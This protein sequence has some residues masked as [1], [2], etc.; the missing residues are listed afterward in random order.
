MPPRFV[1]ARDAVLAA[2]RDG[3]ISPERVDESVRRL[4]DLKWQLA[5]TSASPPADPGTV[6]A[7]IASRSVTLLAMTCASLP[8]TQATPG[9]TGTPGTPGATVDVAGP[10]RAAQAL[11]DSLAARGI[12]A[13]PTPGGVAGGVP[14]GDV[15][16]ELGQNA[17]DP[18]HPRR[19]VVSTG[20]PYH[21]PE[22][23]AAWLATYSTDPASMES[24]AAILT[25]Q[26]APEGRL[27]V[28]TVGV[29]G[30]PLPRGSGL[31]QLVAC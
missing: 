27:P 16:V 9:T 8:V 3:R 7:R 29:D 11:R 22:G 20:T 24:L 25:G 15:R 19:I 14:G 10:P 12:A 21:P 4:L 5:H 23:A 26:A 2:V 18:A 28:D 13:A 31:T 6:A 30:K 17:A 1:E